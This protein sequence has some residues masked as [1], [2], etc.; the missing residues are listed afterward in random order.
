MSDLV[1]IIDENDVV[2]GQATREEAHSKRLL[3]RF[4]HVYVQGSDG[5]W[6]LQ[7][8]SRNKKNGPFKFDASVGGHV[9]AGESYLVAAR[10]EMTEEIGLPETTPL[11]LI[12]KIEDRDGMENMLGQVFI[13]KSDG[14][15]SNWQ[16]EAER[17][18]WFTT[19]ELAHMI[20]RF[21]Y[22]FTGGIISSFRV[23]ES[24]QGTMQPQLR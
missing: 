6:L 4:I 21:P 2:I 14:P 22:L 12:G 17:L 8:R 9:D 10:R 1:D 24:W 7:Q 13:A 20:G 18:E 5:R 16:E 19:A 23:V 15:F 11:E 3:H